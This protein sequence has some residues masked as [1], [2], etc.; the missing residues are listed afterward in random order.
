[1]EVLAAFESLDSLGI[2]QIREWV[3]KKFETM[4]TKVTSIYEKIRMKFKDDE[5]SDD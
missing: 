2:K 1:M 4:D 3:L 5:D